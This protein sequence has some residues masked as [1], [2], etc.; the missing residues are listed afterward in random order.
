MF[1]DYFILEII[2]EKQ[3]EQR[4]FNLKIPTKFTKLR[5]GQTRSSK[6]TIY[7]VPK[8]KHPMLTGPIS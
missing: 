6:Y 2:D 5:V 7:W 4:V 1:E 3:S 8:S